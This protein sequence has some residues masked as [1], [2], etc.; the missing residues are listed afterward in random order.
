MDPKEM[1]KIFKE[2]EE[3]LSIIFND[4]L[5]GLPAEPDWI[6]PVPIIGENELR[7]TGI[8]FWDEKSID[9]NMPEW[10]DKELN[11]TMV[12]YSV[13]EKRIMVYSYL[14][15]NVKT[16]YDPKEW[17]FFEFTYSSDEIQE[18]VLSGAYNPETKRLDILHMSYSDTNIWSIEKSTWL[19]FD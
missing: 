10:I 14:K 13:K 4:I 7:I 16:F 1:R 12:I 17:F 6:D 18:P 9:E 3:S 15:A 8:W 11:E 5:Y 19:I 2:N